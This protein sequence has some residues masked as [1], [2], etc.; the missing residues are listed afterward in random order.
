[1]YD[2][3]TGLTRYTISENMYEV[4]EKGVLVVFVH[5]L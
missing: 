5:D 2:R 3:M 1:M 4:G